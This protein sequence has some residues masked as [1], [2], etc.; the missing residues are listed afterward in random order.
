MKNISKT[1]Q[2]P[3]DILIFV[4]YNIITVR[5]TPQE[6]KRY[7]RMYE[8]V[9]VVNGHAITRMIGTRRFYHVKISEFSERIFHTIKAATAF[10]ETL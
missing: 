2:K 1:F 9:K 7:L 6:R 3:I 10:C 5:G 4:C 8:T